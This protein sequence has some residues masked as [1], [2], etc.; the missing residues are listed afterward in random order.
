M[1]DERTPNP[2]ELPSDRSG[3]L[4]FCEYVRLV[5]ADAAR[6]REVASMG[7]EAAVPSCPGWSVGDVVHHTAEVYLHKVACTQLQR[8]PDPWPPPTH[9]G[10]APMDLFD[11]ARAELLA[12][13]AAHGPE[14]PSHTWWPPEQTVGFWMRRMAL[15]T[16]VHRV[17]AELAHDVVTPVDPALALDGIDELLVAMLAGD[18][19]AEHG[20]A[21]P[22]DAAVRISAAGR[23]WTVT[24]DAGR[25][26]VV[27][28]ATADVAVEVAGEPDAV[29]VWLW[30]RGD[31]ERL[32]LAGDEEV[33]LAVRRRVAEATD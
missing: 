20:T 4:D 10:R 2:W 3:W 29:F 31:H 25:V 23:S 13:F 26:D 24:L 5:T 15:E 14:D 12:M 11:E 27:E 22:V 17:D 33:A 28:A 16:A 9:A 1:N 6:L 30:G 21:E 19:W 7:L 18:D 8:S 32:V